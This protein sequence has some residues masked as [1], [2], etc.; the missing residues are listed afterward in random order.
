M[1][2]YHLSVK[3][4]QRSKG[5][6]ATAAAAYRS[7][8]LIADQRTGEKHDYTRRHGVNF[9]QIITPDGS[10]ID[11]GTLW[12]IAEAAEK[13]KDGTTA[14]EYEIA[15]PSELDEEQRKKLAL[16]FGKLIVQR[17]GVAVDIAIHLPTDK[18]DQRNHHAHI[19]ATTRKLENGELKGKSD[20]DL[21]DRDRK[22]KNLP[23]RKQELLLLR[24]EWERLV[25]EA[26]SRAGKKEKIS[27]KKLE[28]QG[29]ERPPTI[30]LGPAAT[31]ME[32]K[33]VKTE[34]GDLN[35]EAL[36]DPA[37]KI[38]AELEKLMEQEAGINEARARYVEEKARR[39]SD[40]EEKIKNDEME[41]LGRRGREASGEER[42]RISD[43]PH[44][45]Q[46]A[47]QR[48]NERNSSQESTRDQSQGGK[49]RNMAR[50]DRASGTGSEFA[51]SVEVD[52]GSQRKAG[53]ANKVDQAG[54]G[55]IRPE[56]ITA[57]SRPEKY[58][59]SFGG[60]GES[61]E[62]T[63]E[64]GEAGSFQ[65]SPGRD[66]RTQQSMGSDQETGKKSRFS[67][68]IRELEKQILKLA[69][70]YRTISDLLVMA[71]KSADQMTQKQEADSPKP[72]PRRQRM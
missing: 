36:N 2:I 24:E 70:E 62:R 11:R 35:R 54:Y 45:T 48:I 15:L 68:K 58:G 4:V 3:P 65:S 47:N 30:H 39:A 31:A 43:H 55:S 42:V 33:G 46:T 67:F 26:L 27:H 44:H 5:R 21:S 72:A 19:M 23:G 17:H 52:K 69:Q 22:K 40:E 59:D 10:Q 6:S 8:V 71:R 16:E 32:R 28:A 66:R 14:R 49:N 53:S 61:T 63:F 9:I 41:I 7:G 20:F 1:A 25:N 38:F 13:R 37:R 60:F 18:G 12:N 56:N 34:R 57:G 29:I 50:S 51:E 64:P